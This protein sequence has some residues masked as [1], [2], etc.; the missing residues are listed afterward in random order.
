[1]F[2]E[3]VSSVTFADGSEAL[4]KE[5]AFALHADI[6]SKKR[7][8]AISCEFNMSQSKAIEQIKDEILSDSK[9]GFILNIE[10]S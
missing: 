2:S 7:R 6:K 8:E 1:M 5:S 9:S 4:I 3:V 10:S